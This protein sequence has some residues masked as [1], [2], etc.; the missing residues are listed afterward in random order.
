MNRPEVDMRSFRL[1]FVILLVA[2]PL[3]SQSQVKKPL[4]HYVYDGWKRVAG[5]SISN[6]G[7]WILYSAEPQEG[8]GHLIAWEEIPGLFFVGNPILVSLPAASAE[9]S[10]DGRRMSCR[11]TPLRRGRIS[12][13]PSHPSLARWWNSQPSRRDRRR[14]GIETQQR[15]LLLRV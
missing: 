14:H 15:H 9:G 11:L 6:D 8:D 4:S 12:D 1:C 10:M 3:S 7:K 13:L 2:L 5:E